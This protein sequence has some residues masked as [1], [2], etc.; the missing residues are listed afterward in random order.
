MVKDTQ[1]SSEMMA[2][3]MQDGSACMS[4]HDGKKKCNKAGKAG[5]K[6]KNPEGP[7]LAASM[8]KKPKT[9]L[10]PPPPS[11]SSVPLQATQ[12]LLPHVISR[13][14]PTKEAPKPAAVPVAPQSNLVPSPLASQAV[15][16][17]PPSNAPTARTPTAP[18]TSPA[19]CTEEDLVDSAA[20]IS[21]HVSGHLG[22]THEASE[23][24]EMARVEIDLTRLEETSQCNETEAQ[25]SEGEPK[26]HRTLFGG[27]EGTIELLDAHLDAAQDT[28]ER[29]ESIMVEL[30]MNLARMGGALRQMKA[31][32]GM[33]RKWRSDLT[34]FHR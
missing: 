31:D 28:I 3:A 27:P 25:R 16:L 20:A 23:D 19:P 34:G 18:A 13:L 29:A 12:K 33:M 2:E 6:R 21:A 17:F 7:P 8:S 10:A 5:R 24:A 9:I 11:T 1:S 14:V 22:E 26:M 32:V 4:C 15:P 30:Y